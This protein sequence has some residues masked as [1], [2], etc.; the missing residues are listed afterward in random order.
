GPLPVADV[1]APPE[2]LHAFLLSPNESAEHSFVRT[3]SFA[4]TPVHGTVH[5]EFEL[6]T[7]RTFVSNA[8]LWS[9]DNLTTPAIAVPIS[10]PWITGTPYALYAH[11]RAVSQ[12][13]VGPWSEPFGF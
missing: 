8:I 10:L 5:Y 1:P 3:P 12:K 13:G 7:S 11:V 2:G 9:A 4:W 6:S